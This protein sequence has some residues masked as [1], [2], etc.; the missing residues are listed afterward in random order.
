MNALR[1]FC[2]SCAVFI[3]ACAAA[4]S[5]HAQRVRFGSSD[6]D[7]SYD[8]S[9]IALADR[10]ARRDTIRRSTLVAQND[11][12]PATTSFR[13]AI[14]ITPTPRSA[15]LHSQLGSLPS[16]PARP[17]RPSPARFTSTPGQYLVPQ[18]MPRVPVLL[19]TTGRERQVHRPWSFRANN[20]RSSRCSPP[21]CSPAPSCRPPFRRRSSFHL[22]RRSIATP[23]PIIAPA[24]VPPPILP[25]IK[26]SSCYA[27]VDAI[28]FTRN[29]EIGNQP[30]V[31]FDGNAPTQS[32][33]LLSTGDLDFGWQV[34][35][36][37]H[38]GPR[39]RRLPLLRS[40]LLG[41]LQLQNHR[42]RHRQQRSESARRSRPVR[43][44]WISSTPTQ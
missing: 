44:R 9:T 39:F 2:V 24:A 30:L 35:P 14:P 37:H 38:L 27:Y 18:P 41:H 3:T 13:P 19:A 31:L 28:F 34:G 20:A 4:N 11:P 26:T 15:D 36:A 10:S 29:A 16:G 32:N 8:G 6:Q 7:P 40:H 12:P 22:P 21:R 1:C 25:P 33:V 43:L 5:A 42:H 17:T 23:P